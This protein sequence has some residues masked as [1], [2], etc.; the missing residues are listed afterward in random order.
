[1]PITSEFLL[2]CNI[3]GTGLSCY[4][5][6]S[7]MVGK[8]TCEGEECYLKITSHFEYGC[9]SGTFPLQH[10]NQ[11]TENVQ[12]IICCSNRP[13][14]NKNLSTNITV[15]PVIS[16]SPFVT[17]LSPFTS[18]PPY[19]SGNFN[20]YVSCKTPIL[21]G[22]ESYCKFTTRPPYPRL[23]SE[24]DGILPLVLGLSH[25]FLAVTAHLD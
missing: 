18:Q 8:S 9:I 7:C 13:E 1:M 24:H 16:S 10:C 5:T 6:K 23:I 4:C 19:N 2:K 11:T 14:C 15:Y 20:S 25:L 21:V 17:S 12:R 3:L 22:M